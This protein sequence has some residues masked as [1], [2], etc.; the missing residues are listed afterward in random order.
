[1]IVL[2]LLSTTE[3]I[4]KHIY[5]GLVMPFTHPPFVSQTKS[6]SYFPKVFA[7]WLLPYITVVKKQ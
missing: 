3:I 4:W 5:L 2:N 7:V 6:H 1:M